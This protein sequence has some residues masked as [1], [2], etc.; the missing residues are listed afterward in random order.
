MKRKRIRIALAGNPNVGKTTLFNAITGTKQHVGNWPGVTVEK[1]TGVKKF[2][3]YDLEIVD[4]PGTY[5]LTAYSMDELI[6]RNYIVDEQPDVVINI[7]DATNLERNLYL[8]SQLMELNAR[9]V[10]ALN[11]FDLLE[12]RGDELEIKKLEK[13]LE[14]PI[15]KTI[16]KTEEGVEELLEETIKESEK[17]PHHEHIFGFGKDI[18]DKIIILENLFHQY[19]NLS[20]KF[21]VRWLCIKLLEKDKEI[22][23]QIKT[24]PKTLGKDINKYIENIE[25]ERLEL[26]M[27]DKR[28]ENIH[29]IVSQVLRKKEILITPS[30]MIDRV[31]T[32]RYLGIPIFLAIMWGVFELTFTLAE[33]FM[34]ALDRLFLAAGEF[35]SNNIEPDWLA[36]LLGRGIIGGVGFILVFLPTIFILFFILSFLEDSG[37]MA[38]AAFIMDKLMYK[39]GLQ[40][41]SF[42]PLLLGFGCTVPA[43]MSTRTIENRKDRLITI[44]VNPFISCGARLP[45]YI[46]LAGTFFGKQAGTIIFLIYVLSIIFVVISTKILRWTLIKGSP[47]PFIME[48]PP[49]RI[50]TLKTSVLHMWERG[51][52]YLK[53]AGTIIL[54]AA[55]LIWV[56]SSVNSNGYISETTREIENSFL[57]AEGEFNGNG[58]FDGDGVFSGVV[59]NNITLMN[60]T[61]YSSGTNVKEL[62]LS[63]GDPVKG[64]GKFKGKGVFQGNGSYTGSD[65]AIEE[66]FASSIGRFFE[67]VTE[68][69]GFNW[70]IN[71]ALI[72]G[73]AAKEFVVGTLGILYGVG[74]GNEDQNELSSALNSSPD[75][76]PLT[77]FCLMLFV[78]IYTPCIATIAVIKKETGKWRW[79]IFS[80]FYGLGLAWI[81]VF[82]VYNLGI[83]IGYG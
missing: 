61:E 7:L 4:L 2:K 68:P 37:Y 45:V 81:S 24:W 50:P 41:K 71:T 49:Y 65:F 26:A 66:S 58:T 36:S 31:L 63:S 48:L 46:L 74:E 67:P 30:D 20:L 42:I 56:I 64:N 19:R 76:N 15:I 75:F 21:P 78:L 39:V 5:S 6:A 44:L 53:K 29:F 8:T 22:I 80:I 57:I 82:I 9:I 14:I 83:M 16:A 55:I 28:Y 13:L 40:G 70:R 25:S 54:A 32:N 33:P 12:N 52:L 62:K 73:F 38:R 47:A 43:I 35:F 72:F 17:G 79:A 3:G 11:M 1:K 51:S 34:Q 23:K 27:V 60:G 77:A 59:L 10:I 69:L 18:E